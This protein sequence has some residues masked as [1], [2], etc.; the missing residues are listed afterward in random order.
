VG[1]VQ[2]VLENLLAERVSIRDLVTICETLATH[3]R[4]T[5]DP[6][7]L[8]EYCRAAL[9]RQITRQYADDNLVLRVITIAGPTEEALANAVQ[10]TEYGNT[11]ALPPWEAQQLLAA[12]AAQVE[13][14][15]AM[16]YEPVILCS[17]RIRIA[18]RRLLQRRLPNVAVVS[19]AEVA[20]NATVE[21]I[22]SVE[23]QLGSQAIHRE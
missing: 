11:L 14:A 19:Y 16:G 4:T 13:R 8:T 5:R 9:A 1:E 2:E 10:H 18:L 7:L 22:G 23:V 21:A 12:V 15:A 17:S 20:P 3:G 6:D